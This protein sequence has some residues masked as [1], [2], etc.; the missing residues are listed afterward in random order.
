MFNTLGH[1]HTQTT[2]KTKATFQ[3]RIVVNAMSQHNHGNINNHNNNFSIR[4]KTA[5]AKQNE[6]LGKTSRC[7]CRHRMQWLSTLSLSRYGMLLLTVLLVRF[8]GS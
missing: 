1:T 8:I 6:T 5:L 2:N 3:N 4:F 7:R